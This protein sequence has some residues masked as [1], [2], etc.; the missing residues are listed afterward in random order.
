MLKSNSWDQCLRPVWREDSFPVCCLQRLLFFPKH[1]CC[2]S[3]CCFVHSIS[4]TFSRLFFFP[5][6][7]H[8]LTL[9]FSL[10]IW[11]ISCHSSRLIIL[12]SLSC[13]SCYCLCFGLNFLLSSSFL[14]LLSKST[15]LTSTRTCI[16][17]E[18]RQA[19]A[20]IVCTSFINGALAVGSTWIVCKEKKRMCKTKKRMKKRRKRTKQRRSWERKLKSCKN[21]HW[22]ERK[23]QTERWWGRRWGKKYSV[24][25][26]ASPTAVQYK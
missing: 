13:L 1:S 12:Y 9:S 3:L 10:V 23:R 21:K 17:D 4:I 2:V 7:S 20:P 14:L 18:G 26:V 11:F 8:S 16:S 5:L 19:F 15:A 25:S 6:L 22:K 24:D